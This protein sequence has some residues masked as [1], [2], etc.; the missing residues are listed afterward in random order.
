MEEIVWKNGGGL[1]EN[2]HRAID[3][4]KMWKVDSDVAE[5]RRPGKMMGI[6]LEYR[7]TSQEGVEGGRW[8]REK[9]RVPS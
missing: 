1:P 5:K 6:V 7:S 4:K 2:A 8:C 9:W 3:Q